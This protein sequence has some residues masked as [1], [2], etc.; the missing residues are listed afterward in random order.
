MSLH[1]R[2]N[3]C[4]GGKVKTVDISIGMLFLHECTYYASELTSAPYLMHRAAQVRCAVRGRTNQHGIRFEA[5]RGE[6]KDVF[7]RKSKCRSAFSG[8]LGCILAH[9]GY[10]EFANQM[11]NQYGACTVHRR[12]Q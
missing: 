6:K 5:V 9:I 4:V 7:G 1:G 10:R 8:I 2:N 3:K 12:G 11:V